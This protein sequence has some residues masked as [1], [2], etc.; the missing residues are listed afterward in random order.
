MDESFVAKLIDIG[1]ELR[2]AAGQ[3][4]SSPEEP[5]SGVLLVLQGLLEVDGDER[6]A[7]HAIG[8]RERLDEVRVVAR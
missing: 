7:G 4:V 1:T 8:L 5:R 3:V 2:F 6:G